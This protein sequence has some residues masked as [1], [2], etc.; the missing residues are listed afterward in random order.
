MC[1]GISTQTCRALAYQLAVKN[2]LLIPESWE[3][4]KLAGKDWLKGF[5]KRNPSL[6]IRKP[7]ACSLSRATSFNKHNVGI[8]FDNLEQLIQRQPRFADGTCIFNLD[9]TGTMTVPGNLQKVLCKKGI[10][11]VRRL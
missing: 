5:K 4:T 11:Q 8:F 6:T 3:K 9:E 7:E 1:Y 2:N 10:K